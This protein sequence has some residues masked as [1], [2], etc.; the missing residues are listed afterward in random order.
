MKKLVL[1][2]F[3]LLSVAPS[4]A[5][6]ASGPSEAATLAI[7]A[8]APDFNLPG[9]DGK[10]H[11]LADFAKAKLL[12]VVFTCNHCPTAQLY[13]DRLKKLV[14]TYGKKGVA[15]VMISPNDPEAIRPDELGYTDLSDSL[16]E[17]KLRAKE[18][19]F[20]FPYLMGGGKYEAAA[21]AYG[22][23]ATPHAFLFDA[24]RKL[25]YTGR[26]DDAERAKLVK[27]HDLQ[28]AI[29]AL[30][31]GRPVAVATN[32]AFGCSTKW[33]DKR[34]DVKSY[35]EKVA[36]QPVTVSK[37]SLAELKA[38]RANKQGKLRLVNFWATWCGPCVT[39]FPDL[40][41]IHRQ[42][43][44]RDFELVT[45][46]AQYPDEESE[47]LAFLKKQKATNTNLMFGDG[48]KYALMEAFD[49]KWEGGLPFSMLIDAKGKVLY[50]KQGAVEPLEVKRL[51]VKALAP[52][53]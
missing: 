15:F 29:D 53:P 48:D 19:K 3:T 10:N 45:V 36:A 22:P 41:Q 20:N 37:A 27:T 34:A 51:I 13:E 5:A 35:W 32:K 46:A 8:T 26:I 2:V 16:E 44:G 7:G 9:V 38:L 49:K 12:A 24:E 28:D 47:V 11:K 18:R 21:K 17:M 4:L 1:A 25:R 30:L 31:A 52:A 39:E 50:S 6:A 42:Y 40:M 33:S 43:Q 23:K 14:A